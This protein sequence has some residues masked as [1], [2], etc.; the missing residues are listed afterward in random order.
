MRKDNRYKDI[1]TLLP[2]VLDNIE[3]KYKKNPINVMEIWP[4]IIG[5]KLSPMTKAVSLKDG[6]FV[7]KVKSS[8]LYSLL[9]NY[10][11]QKLL[12]KLQNKISKDIVHKIV[13]KIG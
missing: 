3:K 13:F 5:K 2:N 1:K 9:N 7:V 11:K 12:E 6:V 10:E 8:T 4:E